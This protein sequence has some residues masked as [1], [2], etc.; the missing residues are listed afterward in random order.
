ML[1]VFVGL[2]GAAGCDSSSAPQSRDQKTVDRRAATAVVSGLRS[3]DPRGFDA[4]SWSDAAD[5]GA[6]I[7]AGGKVV[8]NPKSWDIRRNE[9]TVD[10]TLKAPGQ[11]PQR[12][13][14]FLHKV[15][16][17]WKVY[18]SLPLGLEQ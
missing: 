6:V 9:A 14:L 16:G 13:W 15:K 12:H 2:I 4:A 5:P 1:V 11:L 7:P 17:K 8:P 10:V 3:N 18:A